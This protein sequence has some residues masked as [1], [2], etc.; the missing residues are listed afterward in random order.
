MRAT[1]ALLVLSLSSTL[2]AGAAATAATSWST[3]AEASGYRTTPRYDE[4]M[5]YLR[6]LVAAAPRTL[7]LETFG[8]T[9]EG[10]DLVIAIA[11][12]GG[13]FDPEAVRRAG[14][15]VVLVQNSIHAGEMDGK[16]A[17]L[18]L[19]RDL[20]VNRTL[21]PLLDRV[22]LVVIPIYNADGHE[23]FGPW[24]RIN[25]NGPEEMG[26][27]TQ[28]RNLNLNRDYMKADAPETRA[29]LAL[30]NRWRPD[31]FI[32]DH[33]TDGADYRYDVTFG[34]A[35]GPDTDPALARWQ[36]D[37]VEPRVTETLRSAGHFPGPF[38]NL[39]DPE[40]PSRGLVDWGATPRFSNGY[41]VL[42]NRPG[43]LVELH[44]LKTYETR[45]RGN[46]ALL[47]GVLDVVN[48]DA[49]TLLRLNR[50]ADASVVAAGKSAD[51]D[52]RVVLR[53]APSKETAPFDFDGV[54]YR[55][56]ASEISGAI[57]IE[58]LGEPA[59][60]KLPRTRSLE[61][62]IAVTPPSA[63]L[64]PAPWTQIIDVLEA[65]GVTLRRTS[66]PWTGEVE[67]HRCEG[68]HWQ[69]K[70]FEGRHPI[71]G[72]GVPPG[73]CKPEKRTMTFP[74]GSVLVPLD[75]AAAKVAVHFLEPEGP[76]SAVAWGFFDAVFEQK[77]FAESY[78]LEKLARRMLAESP[79]LRAEFETKLAADREFAASPDARLDF[80]Y[81]RSPW[82]DPAIGVVPVARLAST[83]GIPVK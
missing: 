12:K 42:R 57:Q 5:A 83:S 81:R 3:P 25:Q 44:M 19:L 6:R 32:D 61:V 10:R 28:S 4:T 39:V 1:T 70:P 63:Y 47:R 37:V 20:A 71:V 77:E 75:Q 69:A 54:S 13:I 38:V 36:R 16:D 65:H 48:R 59:A 52:R 41:I 60:L 78:V 49:E 56:S 7:R 82:W 15:A 18:A 76:D 22:V 46:Y 50:E 11:S 2:P 27:R 40:D 45:V 26:W 9:G 68:L 80:F 43:M 55:R 34:L 51:P 67:V 33:V 24:N 17:C 74:A 8:R 58:W 79:A 73:A 35:E 23:R 53:V 14:R 21:A 62:S 64:V 72:D 66:A 30:W 29:F 31:F